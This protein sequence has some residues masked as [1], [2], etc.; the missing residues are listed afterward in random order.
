[1]KKGFTLAELLGVIVIISV[2][3]I[4]IVP[5][6]I[7][8]ITKNK[9]PA[10]NTGKEIIYNAADQY[11]N[12][13]STKYPKGKSG[14]Y[15]IPIK[16]I[17][18]AGY[19]V[20]PVKEITT[21]KDISDKS[22]MV[23]IY[24]TGNT[25][26]EIK[27]GFDCKEEVSMPLIDFNVNPKGS[28]WTTKRN[29]RILYPI[30]NGNYIARYRIDDGDWINVDID[31]KNGGYTDLVFNETSISKKL[32]ARYVGKGGDTPTSSVIKSKI[33]IVNIDSKKPKCQLEV[34]GTKGSN[35]W[36]KSSKVI[37]RFKDKTDEISGIEDYGLSATN[38]KD[39]NKKT[40]LEHVADGSSFI[41]YGYVKDKA[42][43]EE[44]CSVTFKKDSVS[45]HICGS[46]QKIQNDPEGYGARIF[47]RA[48]D[49]ISGVNL[50]NSTAYYC[51]HGISCGSAANKNC[52]KNYRIQDRPVANKWKNDWSAPDTNFE[53][54][55]SLS[56][57][58]AKSNNPSF[59]WKLCDYAGNCMNSY[60]ETRFKF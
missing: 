33:N 26:Y 34:V 47:V 25:D 59:Y 35:N 27:E 14:K 56:L 19:L 5:T 8:S 58:C 43:N 4:L 30:V 32:E 36:Y 9:Q 57:N 7:N 2:L 17:A 15:C 52:D 51:Y 42:G 16:K 50:K 49:N 38:N 44:T 20:S 55:S 28:S 46:R 60:V 1:M 53:I 29:V 11:I 45:P 3:L 54:A 21:G 41:Y 18:E 48:C 12:A 6:I 24:S 39:Y 37:V 22:V 31:S 40:S 10:E 23:T 13:N